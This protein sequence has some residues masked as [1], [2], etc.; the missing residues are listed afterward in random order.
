MEYA[1][2]VGARTGSGETVLTAQQYPGDHL[3]WY[4]FAVQQGAT[5]GA[6]AD[7]PPAPI[8][9]TVIPGSVTFRGMPNSRWWTFED[10]DADLGSVETGPEDLGRMLLIEYAMTYSDDWFTIPIELKV[11]SLLQVR[12]LVVTDTFGVRTRI[13]PF[14]EVDGTSGAWR[15]FTQTVIG[16]TPT[17]PAGDRFFLPP[18]VV[19]SLNGKP[20]EEV[21]LLRDEMANLAWAV[22][23]KVENARGRARD[24]H[25]Q[26]LAG[27]S[28][29]SALPASAPDDADL[30]YRLMT[31]VPN[32]WVPLVPVLDSSTAT[33]RLRRGGML[34]QPTGTHRPAGVLLEPARDLRLFDEEVPRAGTH[35]TRAFQH[36]RWVDG[37]AHLWMSRRK[38]PGRGE[39]WSGLRFDVLDKS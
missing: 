15:M 13:K 32:H 7:A 24:T 29:P 19:A 6:A 21:H 1:F 12:S 17:T 34:G 20:L 22:E 25:E 4:D 10:A 36:A 33:L 11:G 27:R 2:S 14:N 35:V 23:H 39:G 26:F 8:V 3:E 31:S 18:V 16:A 38:R 9:R 5:L 28:D 30:V 37:S